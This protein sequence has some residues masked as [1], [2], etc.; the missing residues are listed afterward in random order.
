MS[1]YAVIESIVVMVVALISA[2][3]VLKL[4]V[5]GPMRRMRAHI[6]QR[7]RKKAGSGGP[8]GLLAA[9]LREDNDPSAGCAS[10]CESGGC[11]GCNLATRTDFLSARDGADRA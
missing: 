1:I 3:Y 4:I 5:P 9:R 6:A 8:L 10:G 2:Y 7:L 11:N